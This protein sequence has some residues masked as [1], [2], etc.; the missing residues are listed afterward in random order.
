[1]RLILFNT[2][3]GA[4]AG[5][6]LLL[7]P[8][9]WAVVRGERPPLLLLGNQPVS[10]SGWAAT[11]GILGF[12]LTS[13]GFVT[14]VWHPSA[15][16]KD[17]IDTIFGEPTLLLGVILLAAA[18]YLG[19]RPD[20]EELDP[21]AL[22]AV[23]APV[24]WVVFWLGVILVWCTLAII[25][26]NVVGAAPAEEPITG[27]LHDWPMVENLFFALLLYGPAAIGCLLFPV[28]VRGNGRVSWLILYWCWTV[29]GFGFAL[30]SAMNFY[31]HTGMLINLGTEGADYRW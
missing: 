1:M 23:L 7:V 13:L 16:A 4:C 29:A 20:G 8:R 28:A 30:F 3:M 19:R 10:P 31:T 25:R 9:F 22:R 6:A 17:Y 12:V 14:T 27:L 11:F 2:L 21:V 5:I 24:S 18:W 26:F 15:P